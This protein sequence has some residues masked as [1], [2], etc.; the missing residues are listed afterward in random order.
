MISSAVEIVLLNRKLLNCVQNEARLQ[1]KL[2]EVTSSVTLHGAKSKGM[3]ERMVLLEGMLQNQRDMVNRLSREKE[4]KA[5][6]ERRMSFKEAH[7]DNQ[8]QI[9]FLLQALATSTKS[10]AVERKR[11]QELSKEKD[12]QI[13]QIEAEL[14]EQNGKMNRLVKEKSYLQQ[15]LDAT[16]KQL[17]LQEIQTQ[18]LHLIAFNTD[19]ALV[20]QSG[21]IQGPNLNGK[22]QG[23]M[24]HFG[25]SFGK[26]D[27]IRW[28]GRFVRGG[29]S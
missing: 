21:L 6:Q 3:T 16:S 17:S 25:G 28:S 15:Q 12:G 9:E 10:V 7:T 22:V 24:G 23:P 27:P 26:Q 4:Q 13:S 14:K 19:I 20:Q 29:F 1:K 11:V 2:D 8:E 5:W 18:S